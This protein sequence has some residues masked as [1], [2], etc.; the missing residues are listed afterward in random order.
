MATNTDWSK[1]QR[2]QLHTLIV[3]QNEIG[4]GVSV[5]LDK[6]IVGL[7]AEMEVEDINRVMEELNK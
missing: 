6:A 1:F 4:V 5:T 3:V 7:R 2:R